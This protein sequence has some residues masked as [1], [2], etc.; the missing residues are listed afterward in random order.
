MTIIPKALILVSALAFVL[1]VFTVLVRPI[2]EIPAESFSRTCSN[3][4]LLAIAICLCSRAET[5]RP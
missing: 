2:L 3:L 4:A 5:P 1:A